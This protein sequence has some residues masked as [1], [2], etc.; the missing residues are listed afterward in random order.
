MKKPTIGAITFALL[1]IAGGA[2]AQAW[3]SPS[4]LGPH[5]TADLGVYVI[6]GEIGDV[7]VQGIWRKTGAMNLGVRLGFVDAGDGVLQ[8]GLETW[9]DLVVSDDAEF[10]LDVAWTAGIGA[11]INGVSTLSVPAGVSI[12][13]TFEAGSIT[14][15]VYGH[16]RLVLVAF[17]NP[18]DDDLELD[19]EG[20]FDLG[21]DLYL[22]DDVTVRVGV[23]LGEA[24]ALGIG[25]AWRR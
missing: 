18:V 2:Q 23:S 19:L 15:Q 3:N 16:P 1:A 14:M 7:G 24:D 11:S 21:T 20:Q 10:P 13:Q 17:E 8:A 4:F 12:G 6:D 22:S 9:G 5:P 25:V